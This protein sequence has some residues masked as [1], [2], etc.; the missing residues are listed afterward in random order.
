[1]TDSGIESLPVSMAPDLVTAAATQLSSQVGD[2]YLTTHGAVTPQKQ[3]TCW[4]RGGDRHYSSQSAEHSRAT[5]M[6]RFTT[7]SSNWLLLSV[8][9]QVK[10]K[11]F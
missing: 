10:S 6:R 9:T 7:T 2:S 1:M 4:R 11:Q 5:Q 8:P 3:L